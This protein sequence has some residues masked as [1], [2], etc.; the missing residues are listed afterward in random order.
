MGIPTLEPPILN[1]EQH[2]GNRAENTF[3]SM[4]WW[5]PMMYLFC[6]QVRAR[7]I[8]EVGVGNG[9][10]SFWLAHAAKENIGQYYG[11]EIS[12]G[13]INKTKKT[14]ER[15]GWDVPCNFIEVDTLKI[16]AEWVLENIGDSIDFIF[17]DG[18][19]SEE[20]VIHEMEVLY[21]FL[22]S[23][24]FVWL[25]DIYSSVQPAWQ[26]IIGN[27]NYDFKYIEIPYHFGM[28]VLWRPDKDKRTLK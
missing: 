12:G 1:V 19:H 18:D 20:A 15:F 11:L 13:R 23:G 9:Q 4:R 24:G 26:A 27:E 17:L 10:T 6:R 2:F 16:T 14:I 25:H 5:G 7:K 21:P 22:S 8:V 28:G 3:T